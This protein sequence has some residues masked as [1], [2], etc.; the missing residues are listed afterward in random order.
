MNILNVSMGM[1]KNTRNRFPADIFLP[2]IS[3][4]TDL[5]IRVLQNIHGYFAVVNT[6]PLRSNEHE[7]EWKKINLLLEEDIYNAVIYKHDK[8]IQENFDDR[9]LIILGSDEDDDISEIIPSSVKLEEDLTSTI[10]CGQIEDTI[11]SH[12]YASTNDVQTTRPQTSW[13]HEKH[14]S[15]LSTSSTDG[16]TTR[17]QTSRQHEQHHSLLSTSSTNG[18]TTRPQTSR[19]LA[20][21]LSVLNASNIEEKSVSSGSKIG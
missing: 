20:E 21:N 4:A 19:P 14:H 13:Q 2:S 7:R 18:Q 3:S 15:L 6:K 5:H 11:R 10:G 16:Q 12:V 17:P 1:D 8:T 9:D